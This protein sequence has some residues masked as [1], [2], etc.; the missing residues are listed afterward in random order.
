MNAYTMITAY[1]HKLVAILIFNHVYIICNFIITIN[2][3]ALKRVLFEEV[4][5]YYFT[6]V[7]ITFLMRYE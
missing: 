6:L 2:I 3:E 4:I 7:L 5:I 1:L